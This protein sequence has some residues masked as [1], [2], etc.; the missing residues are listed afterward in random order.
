MENNEIKDSSEENVKDKVSKQEILELVINEYR[1]ERKKRENFEVRTGIIMSLIGVILVCMFDKLSFSKLSSLMKQYIT[2]PLFIK[3]IS[4]YASYICIGISLLFGY[5]VLRTVKQKNISIDSLINS[6]NRN[7]CLY[8]DDLISNYSKIIKEHGNLNEKRAKKY[9]Y[10]LFFSIV[11]I[12][13]MI[14]YLIIN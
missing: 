13:L 4:G 14:L 9:K 5:M 1:L 2:F 6:Y 11:A 7:G 3:I 8:Y 10:M 12:G